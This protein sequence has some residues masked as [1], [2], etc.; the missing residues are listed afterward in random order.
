M[1]FFIFLTFLTFMAFFGTFLIIF[2]DDM[3]QF[4]F[5]Y[6]VLI[7]CQKSNYNVSF[8]S[9]PFIPLN[10][11]M[12]CLC[13]IT[14]LSWY[15]LWSKY[16]SGVSG[17]FSYTNSKMSK[18]VLKNIWKMYGHT[19]FNVEKYLRPLWFKMIFAHF[20]WQSTFRFFILDIYKCPKS[21]YL[22]PIWKKLLLKFR[23]LKVV[24]S[25]DHT[26]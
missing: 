23:E 5:L 4:R 17:V 8:S 21:I 22:L 7:C 14:Q 18:N 11:C 6:C 13:I 26:W 15:H 25:S 12:I 19:F 2:R 24:G 1:T 16:F 10:H 3:C 20:F 9:I